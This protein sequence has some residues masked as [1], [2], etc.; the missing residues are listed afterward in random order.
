MDT[1]RKY[2]TGVAVE[3]VQRKLH[4]LGYLADAEITSVFDDNTESAVRS[5]CLDNDLE[6]A[7]CVD[8]V[9]WAK[10]VDETFEL[11]DRVL[12]LRVP[13]FHGQDIKVLQ[14]ALS[15]L[16]FSCGG[17]DGIFGPHTEDAL[18]KFQLNLGLP[19]DGIAGALTFRTLYHLQHSWK[20]KEAFSPA[21]H[22][23]FARAADV[24]DTNYLCLFGTTDFT[25]AVAAR[26]SNLALATTP[27]SKVISAESLL[28]QPDESTVFVQILVGDQQPVDK[29]PV[30]EFNPDESLAFRLQQAFQV[31]KNN[32]ERIALRLPGET[33]E[34]AGE[35]RSAQHYAIVLLDAICTALLALREDG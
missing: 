27:T 5:F 14:K 12:Y 35:S 13:F 2:D 34:D 18:R 7:C 31:A 8:A 10:L 24:L 17:V 19:S 26:M 3:D 29:I 20:D 21:P 4:S 28:V 23:G 15:A 30:V 22:L 33:W 32:A 16:G 1:I 6:E 25:R 9:V 11:G